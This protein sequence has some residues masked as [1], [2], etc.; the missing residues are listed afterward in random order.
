VPESSAHDDRR[1]SAVM[2]ASAQV[3]NL[4]AHTTLSFG[5]L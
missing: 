5:K 1:S 2:A 4:V 3:G